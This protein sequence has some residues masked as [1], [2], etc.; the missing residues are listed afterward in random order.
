[1]EGRQNS[2]TKLPELSKK[3]KDKII[4]IGKKFDQ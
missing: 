2:L 3:K 1:M 4:G